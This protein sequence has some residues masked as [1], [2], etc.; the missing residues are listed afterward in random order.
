METNRSDNDLMETGHQN[1]TDQMETDDKPDDDFK[2]IIDSD[3]NF[4][5]NVQNV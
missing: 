4:M 1:D 3:W 2:S 5:D